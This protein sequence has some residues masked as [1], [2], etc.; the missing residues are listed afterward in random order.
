L[1]K[2]AE[3]IEKA[4]R[5]QLARIMLDAEIATLNGVT[6]LTWKEQAGRTSLDVAS[7][8]HDHPDLVATYMKQQQPMRVMRINTKGHTQ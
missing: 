3:T 7:L 2:Q 4:A 8:K 5:D 1:K 6:V